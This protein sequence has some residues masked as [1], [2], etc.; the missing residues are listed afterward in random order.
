MHTVVETPSYLT[1]A[2]PVLNEATMKAIVDAV[3]ENP[4]AGEV[5]SGTGGFRKL[6]AARPGMGKRGGVR[7]IYLYRN[8]SMPVFLI[9]VYAKNEKANL[10][11]AERNALKARADAIFAEYGVGR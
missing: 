4:E 1:R 6:R 2:E 5:M 8:L 3:A 7:V 9:T 10:T 11:A